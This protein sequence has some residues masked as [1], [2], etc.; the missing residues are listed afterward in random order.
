VRGIFIN[1][2]CVHITENENQAHREL[3]LLYTINKNSYNARPK[4]NIF[5]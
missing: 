2:Y 1:I 4:V 5:V 3:K